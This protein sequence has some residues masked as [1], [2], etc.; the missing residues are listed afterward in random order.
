M[1]HVEPA[2]ATTAGSEEEIVKDAIRSSFEAYVKTCGTK[3]E[4]RLNP[5]S[6]LS[7]YGFR[8]TLVEAL[9]ALILFEE[10]QAL[11]SMQKLIHKLY[12]DG[13]GVVSRRDLWERVV[14]SFIGSYLITYHDKYLEAAQKCADIIL[15]IDAKSALPYPLLNVRKRTGYERPWEN[16][17]IISDIFAGAPELVALYRITK[18]DRYGKAVDKLAGKLADEY[19]FYNSSTG[20]NASSVKLTSE[21]WN[22]FTDFGQLVSLTSE[23]ADLPNVKKFAKLA[24][25]V[26]RNNDGV[27][28]KVDV[29]E[30]VKEMRE[31]KNQDVMKMLAYLIEH[32]REGP[33]FSGVVKTNLGAERKTEVQPSSFIGGW[34]SIGGYCRSN[35]IGLKQGVFNGNGHLLFARD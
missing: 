20:K 15:E 2:A 21:G 11:E 34:L 4:L 28:V 12:C 8:A 19:V 29:N 18:E 3:D 13:L 26:V 23:I 7:T 25:P 16:G 32:A 35:R 9:E 14:A 22:A 1:K 33:G 10:N 27:S 5:I 17:T 31:L 30:L 6:C 24:T